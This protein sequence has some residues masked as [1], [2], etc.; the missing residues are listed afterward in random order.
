MYSLCFAFS[1]KSLILSPTWQPRH[2]RLLGLR[3]STTEYLDSRWGN[4]SRQRLGTDCAAFFNRR[5]SICRLGTDL[6]LLYINSSNPPPFPASMGN[7]SSACLPWRGGEQS[8]T[9]ML[10]VTPAH[11]AG[12]LS[13]DK[14]HATVET[15]VGKSRAAFPSCG[16]SSCT[17]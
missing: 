3:A 16:S 9:R 4:V 15:P 6:G 7:T 10:S 8:G 12:I 17:I 1:H 5:I 11:R 13:A 14:A 2:S